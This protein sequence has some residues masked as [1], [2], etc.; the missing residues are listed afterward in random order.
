MELLQ[1]HE[2]AEG[3]VQYRDFIA[4]IKGVDTEGGRR[5][6][7]IGV[8]ESQRSATT[9][10]SAAPVMKSVFDSEFTILDPRRVT[11]SMLESIQASKT[12]LNFY[13]FR[14]N[15]VQQNFKEDVSYS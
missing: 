9:A 1:P 12:S 7:R 14:A 4:E 13:R 15:Q 5:K 10:G 2:N 11:Y 3:R 8:G 6:G